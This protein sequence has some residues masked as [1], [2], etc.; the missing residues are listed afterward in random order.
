MDTPPRFSAVPWLA[1]SDLRPMGRAETEVELYGGQEITHGLLIREPFGKETDAMLAVKATRGD[2]NDGGTI[3]LAITDVIAYAVTPTLPVMDMR[4]LQSN[5]I[6][7][8]RDEDL[9][10]EMDEDDSDP[11]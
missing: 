11:G 5:P 9:R 2:G 3:T 8:K 4:K 7:V 1:D 6:R 10:R